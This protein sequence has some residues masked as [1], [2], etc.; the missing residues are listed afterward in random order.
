ME[1]LLTRR[2]IQHGLKLFVLISLASILLL[3]F[4]TGGQESWLSLRHLQPQYILLAVLLM[5]LSW[6]FNSLKVK[7]LGWGIDTAIS[8]WSVFKAN[9]GNLFLGA[10][11]PFGMGGVPMQV[12]ILYR[13]GV[14]FEEALVA[15]YVVNYLTQVILFLTCLVVLIFHQG[16]ISYLGLKILFSFV[17]FIYLAVFIFGLIAIVKPRETKRFLGKFGLML[18]KRLQWKIFQTRAWLKAALRGL[19]RVLYCIGIYFRQAKGKLIL[20]I[21][22]GAISLAFHLSTASAIL[23]GLGI[24]HN[25]ADVL[26]IQVILQFILYFSPTFGGSGV[27]EFGAASLMAIFMPTAVLGVYV[28]LWRFFS[29][30]LAVGLGGVVVLGTIAQK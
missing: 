16:L 11:T 24:K 28:L 12:Y 25:F 6:G 13:G 19:D 23:A 30:F 22:M 9:L 1:R 7:I 26:M 10:V 3:V 27:A 17:T 4:L 18:E 21:L 2:S 14:G 5:V 15:S 20:A 29:Y 8:Y